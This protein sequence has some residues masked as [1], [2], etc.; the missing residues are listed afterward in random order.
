MD[1]KITPERIARVIGRHEP[2]IVALQEV[3]VRRH[4]TGGI[5]QPRI[6]AR[7]L[8]MFYHFHPNIQIEEEYYGNAV[9]SRYPMEL[10]RAGQLAKVVGTSRAEPRGA[11]WTVIN[12]AGIKINFF[13]THLG[14][15][16][17]ERIQQVKTL[18]CNEWIGHPACQGPVI[19]CG[20]FNALPSSKLCRNVKEVLRDA[21]RGLENYIPQATWFGHYP[22]GRI[23]HV[24]VSPGIEVTHVE[25]SR[26]DL[27]KISSDH[28]PLIVDIKIRK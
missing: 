27:D 26:T 24:F 13:N 28:L 3:D 20:D 17:R 4:R 1:G 16:P 18:F 11:I 10:I 7:Q 21:Q 15:F 19:L 23:D 22:I 6:I 9:L 5:D 8:E 2:D 12:V 25:V 14:L